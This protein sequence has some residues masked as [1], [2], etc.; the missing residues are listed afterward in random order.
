ME[1]KNTGEKY[2]NKFKKIIVNLYHSGNSVRELSSEYGI[3]E[4]PINIWVK[5]FTSM[6]ELVQTELWV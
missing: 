6:R 3:S 4:V 1:R 5:E 2:N